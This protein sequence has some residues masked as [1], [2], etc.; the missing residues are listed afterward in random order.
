MPTVAGPLV[1]RRRLAAELRRLREKAGK[2]LADVANELEVSTSKLSRL[3]NAQGSPQISDVKVLAGIYGVAGTLEGD[4]LLR[5]ARD[6]RRQA[7]WAEYSHVL[8]ANTADYL[9][10]E[11]EA[12]LL[13]VFMNSIVPGLLQTP[14]YARALIRSMEPDLSAEETDKVIEL[15]AYRRQFLFERES[16]GPLEL[17]VVMH[18]AC[19]MQQVGSDETMKEQLE[20]LATWTDKSNVT[21]HVL[22]FTADPHLMITCPFNHFEFH[23]ALDRDL[24]QIENHAGFYTIE[25][26]QQVKRYH[27]AFDALTKRSMGRVESAAHLREVAGKRYNQH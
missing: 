26:E 11:Y 5:W 10:F 20:E 27:R 25:E 9:A 17:R 1:P 21:V 15:R 23:D 13:R 12:T 4:R 14:D 7:W 16:Q 2:S 3:E 8:F 22:P 18:E 24:V 19:L 6:G